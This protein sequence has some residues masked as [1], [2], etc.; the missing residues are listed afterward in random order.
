MNILCLILAASATLG[1][2][3]ESR[4]RNCEAGFTCRPI[5]HCPLYQEKAGQL[6]VLRATGGVEYEK[7]LSSF[8]QLI[9]NQAENGICC[10]E[11]FEIVNGQVVQ[12]VEEMPFIARIHLK[13]GPFTS[14]FCG[15]TIIASQFLLT[16]KHCLTTFWD[17]CIEELDCVAHFRDLV[18]GRDN[19]EK[20]QFYI[21]IVDIF[22]R[23]GRS[24]LAV[25]K[26]K[27]QIE[28]DKDYELGAKLIPITLA[29]EPPKSGQVS[30]YISTKTSLTFPLL[31]TCQVVQTGGWGLLGYNKGLSSELRSLN[32][33]IT[34]V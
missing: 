1:Q 32:L 9:C 6:T 8:R 29:K 21:P 2:R 11:R 31:F 22:E 23:P 15:A 7:L 33:T 5:H 13:T 27:H 4:D 14:S 28:E 16:A 3:L 12:K 17:N 30:T 20:G 19:H 26:L 18:R 24:D 25:V 10:E 34:T